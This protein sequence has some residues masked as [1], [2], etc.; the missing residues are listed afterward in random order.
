MPEIVLG[1][2]TSHGPTL[3]TAPEDWTVRVA[4]DRRNRH[5]FRG[6]V[7]SYDELVALRADEHFAVRASLVEREKRHAGC[8][9]AIAAMAERFARA[10][11][12]VAII[13]GNDQ[14]ELFLE[15]V[16]PAIT[17]FTGDRLWDRPA[18]PEQAARMPPGIHAAEAGHSPPDYREYP[19]FADLGAHIARAVVADG[20]D[21]AVSKRLPEPPGHWS[22]GAPHSLGFIYRQI[23]R[24]RVIPH[25]PI[26]INTFFPPNQPTARRCFAFGRAVGRALAAWPGDERIAIFGSGG[27]SH[28]TIDEA[29]D[30]RF[31]DA[32]ARRDAEALCAIEESWFQ[33]GTSELKTW[34]AAAG[35]LFDTALQGDVVGYEPCYRSEA[36]TGTANGFVAWS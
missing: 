10:K 5:P 2:W 15:D 28:F 30:A 25:V 3:S 32:L 20:F 31:L 8:Q 9:A 1:M 33:A 22:S 29:F 16:T 13:M 24:D 6:G 7:Y 17:V 11:P 26:I 36:G 34:V 4:A 18:T 23:M 21:V 14:R 27:M 12:D 19:A 35:A